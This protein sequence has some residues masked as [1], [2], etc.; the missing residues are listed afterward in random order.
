L[1]WGAAGFWLSGWLRIRVFGGSV[2]RVKGACFG[3][4]GFG[5]R[6]KVVGVAA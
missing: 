1:M 2:I 4:G 5:L 6:L 3:G